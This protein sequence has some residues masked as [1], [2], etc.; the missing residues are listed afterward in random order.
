MTAS[1]FFALLWFLVIGIWVVVGLGFWCGWLLLKRQEEFLCM[2]LP[3]LKKIEL[4][5][6]TLRS[7]TISDD[8]PLSQL[9]D[10]KLPDNVRVDFAHKK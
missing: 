2:F 9:K 8:T 6:Q 5:Q 10:L 3:Y 4:D 1:T 7:L